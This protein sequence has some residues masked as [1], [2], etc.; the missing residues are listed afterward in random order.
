MR[1]VIAWSLAL[2]LAQF[3]L[4]LRKDFL[5]HNRRNGDR[6]PVLRLAPDV[7]RTPSERLQGGSPLTSWNFARPIGI[8]C[9]GIGWIRENVADACCGS[10]LLASSG[11][12]VRS[13]QALRN[14]VEGGLRL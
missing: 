7:T 13:A 6:D 4:Y 11:R 1:A 3:G 9:A 14:L 2:V 8:R 12:D 5:L 10:A